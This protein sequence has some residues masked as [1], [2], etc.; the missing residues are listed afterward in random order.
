MSASFDIG[1]ETGLPDHDAVLAA[2]HPEPGRRWCLIQTRPRNEKWSCRNLAAAGG[3]HSAR[4]TL[5]P[6]LA[7]LCF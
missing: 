2:L 3:V 6:F 5:T 4:L 7:H 1:G